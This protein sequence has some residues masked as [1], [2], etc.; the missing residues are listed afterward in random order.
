VTDTPAS[1]ELVQDAA[2]GEWFDPYRDDFG[3]E[4]D[5]THCG[6]EGTCDDNAD[7]LGDCDDNPHPC[8]ACNGSGLRRDQTIF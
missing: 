4:L 5:C 3:N 2:T 8:H 1:A 7:P 6:G